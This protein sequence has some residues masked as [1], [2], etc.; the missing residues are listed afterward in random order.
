MTIKGDI[1]IPPEDFEVPKEGNIVHRAFF[2]R[3]P[4]RGKGRHPGRTR[5]RGR[6]SSVSRKRA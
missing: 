3:E 2:R 4:Q 6:G 5:G 1:L